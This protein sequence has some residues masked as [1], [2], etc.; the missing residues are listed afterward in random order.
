MPGASI[1]LGRLDPDSENVSHPLTGTSTYTVQISTIT[2]MS[3]GATNTHDRNNLR[4]E[5]GGSGQ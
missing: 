2:G 4:G 3:G 5:G 1:R